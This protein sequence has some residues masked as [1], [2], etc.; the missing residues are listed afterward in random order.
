[1]QS[2]AKS[3]LDTLVK[4]AEERP[5]RSRQP[6]QR[7]DEGNIN[8][9]DLDSFHESLRQAEKLGA[10][11]LD[12]GKRE[13]SHVLE[14]V[15]LVDASKACRALGISPA[16]EQALKSANEV[17]HGI[18]GEQVAWNW[19]ASIIDEMEGAWRRRKTSFGVDVSRP[20][21][22]IAAIRAVQ[23]I[24][25]RVHEGLDM[26]TFS[27]RA[28]GDTKAVERVSGPI[29]AL[30]RREFDLHELGYDQVFEAIGLAKFPQ[31]V[32][33]SGRLELKSS[34][35]EISEISPYIGL[36][37]S[38]SYAVKPSGRPAYV[39]TIENLASFNR[40]AREISDNGLI[41]YTGGYPSH[42]VG[43]FIREMAVATDPTIPWFHW[44]DIDADGLLIL[45]KISALS[46]RE[47]VPHLMTVE[48]AM[49]KGGATPGASKLNRLLLSPNKCRALAIFLSGPDARV[50][51]QEELDPLSPLFKQ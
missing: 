6:T 22:A 38:D 42:A 8:P 43:A 17:R 30:C 12:W 40:Y 48:I 27:R 9:L 32:L 10:I 34:G 16:V 51:E 7:V 28:L 44:G 47:V 25:D 33:V 45:D 35:H 5:E 26:R 4:R 19:A 46:G 29:I 2:Q 14:R 18:N 24:K 1:M 39:L 36:P 13:S 41:I 3:I 31:P 21:D 37:P 50:L 11:S 23:A 49:S 15:R 20:N